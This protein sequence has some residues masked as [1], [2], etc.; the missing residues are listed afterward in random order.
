MWKGTTVGPMHEA[1]IR[2]FNP[3][4]YV[5]DGYADITRSAE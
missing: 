1:L 3:T 5:V 4:A 2:R